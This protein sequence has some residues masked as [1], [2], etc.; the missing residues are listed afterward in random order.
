MATPV[1]EGNTK[2]QQ[3]TCTLIYDGDCR[4]CVKSKEGLLRLSRSASVRYIP[5]QSV[6]AEYLLGPAYHSGRPKVA[7]LMGTDGRLHKGID[8]M[9]PLLAGLPGGW[10]LKVFV[11]IPGFR[12]MA[13][14]LYWIVARYRYVFGVMP[15]N[16]P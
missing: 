16:G 14:W 6:E 13:S 11:A 12:P 10:F 8:A 4:F 3:N 7:Y 15:P 1:K 2:P 5:Y 9:L